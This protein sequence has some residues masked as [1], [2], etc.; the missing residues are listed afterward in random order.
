[1]RPRASNVE[2]TVSPFGVRRCVGFPLGSDGAVRGSPDG[3]ATGETWVEGGGYRDLVG[4]PARVSATTVG[5]PKASKGWTT[6]WPLGNA[7]RVVL[8]EASESTRVT[9][10]PGS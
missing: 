9:S 3:S 1:M 2:L 5:F 4:P 6:G 7:T 10:P 8:P